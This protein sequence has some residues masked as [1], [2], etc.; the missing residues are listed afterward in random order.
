MKKRTCSTCAEY[1]NCKDSFAAWIFFI[2]GLTA[3]LAIRVVIVLIHVNPVYAKLAWYVGILG[4]FS[5]FLYKFRINHAR[6]KL[7]SS[8]GLVQKLNNKKK[9]EDDDYELMGN[10]LCGLTSKKERINYFFIFALSAVAII[11]AIYMDFIK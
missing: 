10:I 2:V 5:F 11:L 1:K 9:L 8:Q 6:A 7:I 4:F 3:T